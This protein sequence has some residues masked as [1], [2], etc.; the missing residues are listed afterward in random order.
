MKR[1]GFAVVPL[2]V[3]L[4]GCTGQTGPQGEQGSPGKNGSDGSNGRSIVSTEIDENGDLIITYDDGT[5]ENAGH[6]KD[7]TKYTVNFY[8]GDAIVQTIKV[9]PFARI[10]APTDEYLYEKGYIVKSWIVYTESGF[11]QWGFD[12]YFYRIYEDTDLY[13]F[14]YSYADY[15]MG[16]YPQTLVT[17]AKITSELL[18]KAGT[19][20]TSENPQ[21]W[22]SYKYYNNGSN[23]IDF[24][25]YQDVEYSNEKYRG[26][27]FTIYRPE[28]CTY[29]STD[30]ACTYHPQEQ[31]GYKTENVYWFKWEDIKWTTL[32]NLNGDRFVI[33]L[34]GLDAQCFYHEQS[35][36]SR[37]PYDSSEE[38]QAT[39][40]DWKYSDIRG[41]LNTTFYS[42]AF[43]LNE[44]KQIKVTELDNTKSKEYWGRE[45]YDYIYDSTSDK[46]FILSNEESK[47]YEYAPF[48]AR[49]SIFTD[50]ARCQ[51]AYYNL[52]MKREGGM[53]ESSTLIDA[54]IAIR[55]A[56]HLSE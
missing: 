42:D 19:L 30:A 48:L 44:Q 27:Y 4:M 6:L 31:H 26:V 39:T 3:L 21:S 45:D 15:E 17:E 52:P 24:M 1:I 22:T 13:A 12:G 38:K 16:T 9:D 7:T 23:D 56:M 33:S 53:I 25:W 14:E 47:P 41:W 2:I 50:Y 55:P 32:T 11:Q 20:P 29:D 5:K 51:G 35:A 49:G 28:C 34:K 43:T 10:S 18:K 46:I 40:N 36:T 37:T 54:T 8:C